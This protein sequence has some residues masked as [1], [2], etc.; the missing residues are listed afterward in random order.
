MK[1]VDLDKEFEIWKQNNERELIKV[2]L[3]IHNFDTYLQDEWE[4]YQDENGLIDKSNE[5]VK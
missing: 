3:E 5:E 2:F 1:K 4:T